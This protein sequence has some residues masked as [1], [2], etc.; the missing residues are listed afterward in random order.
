MSDELENWSL[1]APIPLLTVDIQIISEFNPC[2]E[3]ETISS[4]KSKIPKAYNKK[5][6]TG[7][8]L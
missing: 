4:E 5:K 1:R 7:L 2:H 3:P 8:R 6:I